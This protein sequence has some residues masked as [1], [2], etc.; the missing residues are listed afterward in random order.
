MD[1]YDSVADCQKARTKA[2]SYD[3]GD[4]Q[5]DPQAYH[6]GARPSDPG[7][8]QEW[9]RQLALLKAALA[10]SLHDAGCIASDDPRLKGK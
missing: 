7:R 9:D 3:A 10:E 4:F 6:L 2:R 5:I 1:A 8:A